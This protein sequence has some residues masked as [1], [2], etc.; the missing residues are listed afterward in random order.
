MASVDAGQY[1]LSSDEKL[2][3]F[4]CNPC[5]D[6]GV[7]RDATYYC[8]ECSE[9]FCSSCESSLHRRLKA[10]KSHKI[11]P[12]N[13]ATKT[14]DQ[15]PAELSIFACSCKRDTLV[16]FVC[17][18]HKCLVC[19]ECKVIDHR[20]CKTDLLKE[21]SKSSNHEVLKPLIHQAK[22]IEELAK[23]ICAKHSQQLE[24]F[25]A[26][27]VKCREEVIRIRDQL[28]TFIE[29][30][31]NVALHEL[32]GTLK[33]SSEPSNSG[34]S[35]CKTVL[36]KLKED[37]KLLQD[38]QESGNS[39]QIFVAHF[40]LSE[41]FRKYIAL[42]DDVMKELTCQEESITF[43]PNAG[44]V[45]IPSNVK[46]IGDI[47]IKHHQ[48]SDRSNF[49]KSLQKLKAEKKEKFDITPSGVKRMTGCTFLPNGDFVVCDFDSKC[50]IVLGPEFNKTSRL[51]VPSEVWDVAVLDETTIIVSLTHAKQLQIVEVDP[52]LKLKSCLE[53]GRKCFDVTVIASKIYVVCT[54]DPG[55][56]EIRVLNMDGNVLKR[57]GYKQNGSYLFQYPIH[58]TCNY[59]QDK[60]FVSD[61]SEKK[62]V[63]M[64]VEGDILY[65]FTNA[66]V[67]FPR[68]ILVDEE[69]NFMLCSIDAI[70]LVEAGGSKCTR[71]LTEDNG[72]NGQP[73]AL[74]YT[75]SDK[76][77]VVLLETKL[78]VYRLTM[79]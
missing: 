18:E 29:K 7:V 36:E 35:A 45:G 42:L 67:K 30:L 55:N 8:P 20:K 22:S 12:A 9:Y 24:M 79:R 31:A 63:C 2:S 70:H 14:V 74:C 57:L 56:G 6:D 5:K 17:D 69:G 66:E 21:K 44:L 60:I 16:E 23:Q 43:R 62:V 54:D 15:K 72:I 78:L 13:E 1:S 68:G 32:D 75:D 77:L 71:F 3:E 59:T 37:Q 65:G 40:L 34:L 39:R 61:S 76:S 4:E 11:L 73:Y 58:M 49:P 27:K 41:T 53:V 48:H 10:T 38:V 26:S 33:D 50:I 47:V 64:S 52:V 28:V 51:S 19:R 25:E 46:S